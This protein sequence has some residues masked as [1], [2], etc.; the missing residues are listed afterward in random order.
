MSY[1]ITSWRTNLLKDFRIPLKMLTRPDLGSWKPDVVYEEDGAAAFMIGEA[2]IHGTVEGDDL[3]VDDVDISGECS[4]HGFNDVF[5]PAFKAAKG[6]LKALLT[7]EG[8]DSIERRSWL[9][10]KTTRRAIQ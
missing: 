4:G 6:H 8:G 7:W 5:D 10:G 3:V 1:N 9:N 2:T